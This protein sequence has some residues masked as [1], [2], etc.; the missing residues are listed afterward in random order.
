MV[1]NALRV[2]RSR[3]FASQKRNKNE[4]TTF[5]NGYLGSRNDDERSEM[6]YVMW[7]A[8]FSESSNPWT[9]L[10]LAGPPAS[11]PVPASVHYLNK[12]KN[13]LAVLFLFEELRCQA[14]PTRCLSLSIY[15]IGLVMIS[16]IYRTQIYGLKCQPTI[17]C[18]SFLRGIK[19]SPWLLDL[20]CNYTKHGVLPSEARS[21][22]KNGHRNEKWNDVKIIFIWRLAFKLRSGIR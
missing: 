2:R 12:K 18:I 13:T 1:A 9:Q 16:L 15:R 10:A 11:M 4:E 5:N 19:Y 22:T 7:I 6:R 20:T 21:L 17:W 14:L 8:E 3:I